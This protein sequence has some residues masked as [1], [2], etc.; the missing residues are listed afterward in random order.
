METVSTEAFSWIMQG[1][2]AGFALILLIIL[3]W[4]IGKLLKLQEKTNEIISEHNII[5]KSILEG[6]NKLI[7]NLESLHVKLISRPCIATKE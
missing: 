4:L 5:S 3:F 6:Q 1:G 2:F 7:D